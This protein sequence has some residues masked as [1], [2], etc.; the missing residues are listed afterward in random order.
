MIIGVAGLRHY[1]LL[2]AKGMAMGA[3][4]VVPGVSG[5]TIA[6]ISGIYEELVDSLKSLN[7]RSLAVLFREGPEA[8]W[9]SINGN[10]LLAL[11]SGILVSVFSLANIVHHLLDNKPLFVWS[12]FFGLIAASIIYILRQ[13]RLFK[14][15]CLLSVLLGVAGGLL[16]SFAPP[17]A[18]TATPLTLFLSGMLAICAMVLPGVSGSFILL[19]I[20]IYPLIIEAITKFQWSLLATFACGAMIGLIAFSNLLSWFLHHYRDMTLSI[21]TGFLIGSLPVVWPWKLAEGADG[22]SRVLLLPSSYG[23]VVGPPLVAQCLL[24]MAA[25]LV[26]VLGL[27]YAGSWFRRR[28]QVS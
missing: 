2:F 3:A 8:F 11:F 1:L 14:P 18:I 20:G 28:Q 19:L 23:E 17:M 27:E 9:R 5:G 6:F 26:L 24:L 21:L 25:G 13:F 7:P 22:V 16:A 12:F 4:D 15:L 10:F